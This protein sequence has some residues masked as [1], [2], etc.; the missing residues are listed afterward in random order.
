MKFLVP[1]LIMTF[2]SLGA[3]AQDSS[4]DSTST[5]E[6]TE[7][8]QPSDTK[9][10]PDPKDPKKGKKAKKDG[11][12]DS[13]LSLGKGFLER[14]KYRFNL[15]AVEEKVEKTQKQFKKKTP[16]SEDN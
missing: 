11:F 4:G 14:L 16:K 2:L 6:K 13:L 8:V 5:S 7:V 3:L 9:K 10:K 15:E 1:F 12:G